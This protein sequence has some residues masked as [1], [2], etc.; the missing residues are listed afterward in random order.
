MTL[1]EI[2]LLILTGVAAGFLNVVGGGGSLITIPLMIFIGLPPTV[3][4]ASNRVALLAQ[5]AVALTNFK[6]KK[7]SPGKYGLF[8]AIAATIGALVGAHF[9]VE[10]S[11]QVFSRIISLVMVAVAL[12]MLFNRGWAPTDIERLTG[13]YKWIGILAFFFIGIYGGFIQAGVG[14]IMM[15]ALVKVNRISLVKTNVIKVTVVLIYTIAALVIFEA[16][17]VID[18]PAG[19][20]LAVG[21]AFGGWLGSNFS[22]K[23]G[24]KW[25]KRIMLVAITALAIR[26]WFFSV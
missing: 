19:L 12:L 21:N 20:T 22:M 16:E 8:V 7:V 15:L 3:A 17:D 14:F 26:L 25:I 1:T 10:I 23:K 24:D 2:I 18:W 4:N 9:A 13:K 6:R 5:N 11:E